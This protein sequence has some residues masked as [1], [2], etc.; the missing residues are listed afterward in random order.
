MTTLELGADARE[1]GFDP[2]R[3]DNI[4][5]FFNRYVDDR[6][7]PGYL[8]TVARSGQLVYTTMAGFRDREA[9]LPVTDDT[10]F[11]IYSMTKPI[12]SIAAMMLYEQGCFDLND[13]AGQW[14]ESLRDARVY[15]SGPPTA[16][17]TV[18]AI[19]PVRVHHLLSHTSGLTYGFTHMHPVDAIYRAKGYEFGFHRDADLA[20]AVE[21]WCSS[22]LVFQPGTA[23]NYSVAVDVIGRLI[24]IWSGQSLDVFFRERILDPLGMTDTDWYCPEDVDGHRVVPRGAGLGHQRRAAPVVDLSLIHI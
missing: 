15:V 1:F 24:E 22:P 23:W 6:R 18:P 19:E 10:I 21:D 17:T 12:T 8:V 3:L 9:G 16:P 20:R 5:T 2:R 11:R 13:P 7:L 4:N 14:I